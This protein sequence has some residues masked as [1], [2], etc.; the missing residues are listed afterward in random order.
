LIDWIWELDV[1][2]LASK[3]LRAETFFGIYR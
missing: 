1:H 2:Y 3:I